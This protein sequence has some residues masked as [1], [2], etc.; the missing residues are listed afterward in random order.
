MSCHECAQPAVHHNI[1]HSNGDS[2]SLC[3][4]CAAN[5]TRCAVCG[6]FEHQTKFVS[7]SGYLA[8]M[9]EKCSL[10]YIV[11]RLCGTG[12]SKLTATRMQLENTVCRKCIKYVKFSQAQQLIE[13][14]LQNSSHGNRYCSFELE[15]IDK[16]GLYNDLPQPWY[17]VSDGSLSRYGVELINSL[18][19]AGQ[20][21]IDSVNRLISYYNNRYSIDD[22]CG[23][24]LHLDCTKESEETIEKFAKF[25]IQI[26]DSVAD[27][28]SEDRQK[29][30]S[31]KP[32][33]DY[34]SYCLRLPPFDGNQSLEDYVYCKLDTCSQAAPKPFGEKYRNSRYYWWN[35]H[36]YFYRKTIECRIHH[37]TLDLIKIINWAELWIKVFEWVKRQNNVPPFESIWTVADLAKVKPETIAFYMNTSHLTKEPIETNVST[38][39]N[40]I[41]NYYDIRNRHYIDTSIIS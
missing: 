39:V 22:S 35:F 28:M 18:P 23:Y 38:N 40:T 7:K 20:S 31:R 8:P 12:F 14:P 27:F 5:Y 30:F 3:R 25:C 41:W 36:S 33:S 15:I 34:K 10:T 37:G 13:Y 24:H 26:Q 17:A 21:I 29:Q 6:R 2:V 32:N 4:D 16:N 9:C 19:L 11:C 1:P